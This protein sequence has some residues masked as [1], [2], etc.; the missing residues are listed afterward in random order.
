MLAG[1]LSNEGNLINQLFSSGQSA[2]VKFGNLT[3]PLSVF[4]LA[5]IWPVHDFRETASTLPSAL[6]IGLAVIAAG[7]AL[8]Y[9]ARRRQFGLALYVGVA[10]V[11]AGSCIS[12]AARRG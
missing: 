1:F 4:Q 8:F 7:A 3:Q 11:G 6:F 10:L 9:G 5:G 12:P 2:A